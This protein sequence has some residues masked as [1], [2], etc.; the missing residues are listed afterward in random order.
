VTSDIDAAATPRVL[1]KVAARSIMR[2]RVR[3]PFVR[4][5]LALLRVAIAGDRIAS[6]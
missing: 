5:S 1:N 3:A 2:W 6:Q 4:A